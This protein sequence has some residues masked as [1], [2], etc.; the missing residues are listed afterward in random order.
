MFILADDAFCRF[1]QHKHFFCIHRGLRAKNSIDKMKKTERQTKKRILCGY[2]S[3]HHDRQHAKRMGSICLVMGTPYKEG[4]YKEGVLGL[5]LD[6]LLDDMHHRPDD[7]LLIGTRL[8][9]AKAAHKAFT[10]HEALAQHCRENGID[11]QDSIH[12]KMC[13]ILRPFI[14]GMI[15]RWP[16]VEVKI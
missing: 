1:L 11:E 3:A 8:N 13:A 10:T 12:A 9:M 4:A 7:C 2:T 16:K 6:R 15:R 5:S 14:K